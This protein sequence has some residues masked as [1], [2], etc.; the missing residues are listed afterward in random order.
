MFLKREND[1]SKDKAEI[2]S[3]G[4]CV[5]LTRSLYVTLMIWSEKQT[6]QTFQNLE[7]RNSVLGYSVYP[8]S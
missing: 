1:I 4:K 2:D 3:D 6:S 8:Y 5:L 7:F